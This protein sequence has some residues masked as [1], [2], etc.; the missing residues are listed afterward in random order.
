MYCKHCGSEL[1]KDAAFCMECGCKLNIDKSNCRKRNVLIL[2]LLLFGVIAALLL[3]KNFEKDSIKENNIKRTTIESA[4]E[5]EINKTSK[6]IEKKED[7][8]DEK[9]ISS[10]KAFYEKEYG[11]CWALPYIVDVNGD[12][13]EE[14]LVLSS[15]A[16]TEVN[17][18]I[19]CGCENLELRV[20]QFDEDIPRENCCIENAKEILAQKTKD[21]LKLLV[22]KGEGK[23]YQYEALIF[24]E[25]GDAE[26]LLLDKEEYLDLLPG[27]VTLALENMELRKKSFNE[28][29]EELQIWTPEI[30]CLQSVVSECD[31]KIVDFRIVNAK[32]TSYMFA[33]SIPISENI[34]RD[35]ITGN[36]DVIKD[37]YY[38]Y[39][40]ANVWCVKIGS[41]RV[42]KV[43]TIQLTD[44][45]NEFGDF[46]KMIDICGTFHFPEEDHYYVE[47]DG[48]GL[49]QQYKYAVQR[50]EACLIDDKLYFI[51][52]DRNDIYCESLESYGNDSFW[53]NGEFVEVTY[54]N[55]QYKQYSF[56]PFDD[57][58]M[59]KYKNYESIKQ[60]ME[61]RISEINFIP[62]GQFEGIE[63]ELKNLQYKNV[64]KG[65]NGKYCINYDIIVEIYSGER[66]TVSLYC[67]IYEEANILYLEDAIYFAEKRELSLLDLPAVK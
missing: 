63:V 36:L 23:I 5:L 27:C 56:T 11:E 29:V 61:K 13:V 42:E 45:R 22:N 34:P 4:Q 65:N 12:N 44:E 28:N 37:A 64:M 54:E 9:I 43:D 17:E 10:M 24:H 57:E 58:K 47:V 25:N 48:I 66:Y 35:T 30:S 6:H 2:I 51:V 1:S 41:K 16:E 62:C 3:K 52:N 59:M 14:L 50:G 8:R 7:V 67:T 31:E 20:Y 18:T 40:H 38:S 60:S 32:E 26:L 33:T 19:V 53:G 55:G 15:K 39:S 46:D 21:G 49:W